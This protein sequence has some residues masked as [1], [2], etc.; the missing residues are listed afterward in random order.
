MKTPDG[1]T[2]LVDT[3]RHGFFHF[4]CEGL[5]LILKLA[6]DGKVTLQTFNPKQKPEDSPIF[7]NWKEAEKAVFEI[8]DNVRKSQKAEKK[9]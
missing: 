3:I 5:E 8:F 9:R 6:S 2:V 1:R 4:R 7:D